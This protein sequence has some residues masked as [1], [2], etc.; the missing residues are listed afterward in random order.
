[1]DAEVDPDGRELV[2]EPGRLGPSLL[3]QRDGNGRVA[4]HAALLVE[5][6]MGVPGE[7]EQAQPRRQATPQMLEWPSADP[8]RGVA[9]E[10]G[11]A[12]CSGAVPRRPP[13]G[14]ARCIR[15]REDG[16]DP[17]LPQGQGPAQHPRPARRPRAADDGG[18]REPHR[19]L[20]LEC[21]RE[22]ARA[23]RRAAALRLRASRLGRAG[24][25][26]HRNRRR[27]GEAGSGRLED[28]RGRRVRARG[29]RGARRARARRAPVDRRR[30]RPG[31]GP[32]CRP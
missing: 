26:V 32:A 25:A 10:P 23:P 29:P 11:Q 5:R 30:A 20:V 7:D 28:A 18:G 3:R 15:S 27:P 16:E 8:G 1:M 24:L 6:G 31:R 19:R 12:H 21:R 14:R 13:R 9:R 22:V 17:R 2:P 4:V